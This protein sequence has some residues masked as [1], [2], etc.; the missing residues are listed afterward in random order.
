MSLSIR[1]S[2][3]WPESEPCESE[4]T[5]TVVTTTPSGKYID[6]R[7]LKKSSTSGDD[8]FDWYF[9]GYEIERS[10]D[11]IEFNH[12]FL[13]SQ[14]IDYYYSHGQSASGFQIGL[15]IGT[16]STSN[17]AK[18]RDAGI[19]IETGRMKNPKTDKIE[20]YVEKWISCDP[21][22]T[23]LKYAEDE[24]CE[25]SECVVLDTVKGGIVEN[26]GNKDVVIGR[27]IQLGKWIQGILWDKSKGGKIESIGL[28]RMVENEEL[29]RYGGQAGRFPDLRQLDGLKEGDVISA[30]GELKW[31]VVEVC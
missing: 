29:I 30:D 1:H 2:I 22:C 24:N 12:E 11:V 6:I 23:E 21:N 18:E 25:V 27:F 31:K 14:Y 4:P 9:A 20:N 28:L 7:K 19:R 8:E 10:G 3:Y 17:D 16:F 13:D 15:D 5:S 26:D